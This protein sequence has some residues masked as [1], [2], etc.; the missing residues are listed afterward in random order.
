MLLV[1]LLHTSYNRIPFIFD[2]VRE[3]GY[4]AFIIEKRHRRRASLEE[5]R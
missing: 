1:P 5:T 2:G 3:C 4:T